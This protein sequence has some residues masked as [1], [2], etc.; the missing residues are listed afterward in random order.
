MYHHRMPARAQ[1]RARAKTRALGE[2]RRMPLPLL[3]ARH[4]VLGSIGPAGHA[5]AIEMVALDDALGRVLARAVVADRDQPPFARVTR[6]GFAV[7]AGDVDG[8]GPDRPAT[9]SVIGEAVPGRETA[10]TVGA[11]QCVEIMTG[12]ALPAGADA[13]VMVEHTERVDAARVRILR[14][15]AVGDNVVGRGSELPAGA[16]AIP[17]RRRLDPS[18]IA[19]AASLGCAH[20]S[21][22]VRPRVAVVTTGDEL[23]EVDARPTVTQI[24]DSNRRSLC[25]QVA[26]AGGIAIA[27]PIARD[28]PTT[29]RAVI[30]SA[31]TRADLLLLSGGVSM[32]KY[33]HV[34]G[35]LAGLGAV[36][37]FDGVAIRPGR[38]L[39]FGRVGA[40]PFFG[41][42]GNPLSTMV[43]F[44]LLVRPA[45][46]RLAG[47]DA[48]PLRYRWA[49][50]AEPYTQR[51]V[52]LTV[53]VPA[54]LEGEADSTAVRPLA[55]Q[56]SGDLTAMARADCL[57]VLAP[58]T[59]AL[60]AGTM[61]PVL[62]K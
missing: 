13:V 5:P 33:D 21:V 52:P 56:G 34:E 31:L 47:A 6:D 37:V 22:H 23:V 43:T 54:R 2:D 44:E 51:H 62:P 14:A 12:A 58:G 42:P 26:R 18:A 29:L 50:L 59:T 36:T 57:M 48:A 20:L 1:A 25:A 30:E 11:R 3:D 46:D 60:L 53:F 7:R 9:L 40:V 27:A 38:P 15:L 41:L 45:L 17:A 61:V 10:I 32:G 8:S 39:V 4:A 24:R 49:P 28:D 35:V 55:S 19:L 16:L